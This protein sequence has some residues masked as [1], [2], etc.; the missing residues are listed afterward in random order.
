MNMKKLEMVFSESQVMMLVEEFNSN[1][2]LVHEG[3]SAIDKKID[4]VEERLTE[5]IEHVDFKVEVLNK[6]IDD[7]EARLSSRIDAV[8]TRLG[9]VET[10]LGGESKL[11]KV[12]I[13]LDNH[14]SS[15]ELH[16][17]PRKRPLK[18]I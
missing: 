8:E 18:R 3:I 4:H 7:V 13:D 11:D 15:T 14:R 10:R 16:Q 6:K 12:A 9:A 17:A 5:K 2:K 1:L